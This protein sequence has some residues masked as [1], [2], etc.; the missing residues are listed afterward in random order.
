MHA[1]S[2]TPWSFD[3]R[4]GRLERVG[5][6]VGAVA[7]LIGAGG[8]V[9]LAQAGTIDPSTALIG[10]VTYGPFGG[11]CAYLLWSQREMRREHAAERERLAALHSSERAENRLVLRELAEA[12]REGN[13]T[14]AAILEHTRPR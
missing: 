4:C 11:I 7:S 3:W 9:V 8:S 5:A 12:T 2:L 13:E 1:T 10:L 6:A 14:L